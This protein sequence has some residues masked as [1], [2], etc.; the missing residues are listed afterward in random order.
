ME[1][2]SEILRYFNTAPIVVG[3]SSI[4][5]A[6]Y[7][8]EALLIWEPHGGDALAKNFV[9]RYFGYDENNK[10]RCMRNLTLLWLATVLTRTSVFV[11]RNANRFNFMFMMPMFLTFNLK[12]VIYVLISA[13][14]LKY[15]HFQPSTR[16]LE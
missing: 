13:F 2:N 1:E 6:R 12:L 3:I 10:N 5:Y 7:F 4:S 16:K 9:L 8:L 11:A 14:V 15:A